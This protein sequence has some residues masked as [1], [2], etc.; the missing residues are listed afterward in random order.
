MSCFS[1]YRSFAAAAIL[2]AGLAS[3]PG[4]ESAGSQ[5]TIKEE[6]RNRWNL[7]RVGVLYQLAQQQ[8]QVG[9][10]DKCRETLKQA[11]ALGVPHA[12]I[13]IL[14]AKVDL[15][16]GNL[17]TAAAHL[18][19]ATQIDAAAPEPYYLLG[20]TYQRWQNMQTAHDYYK[21]AWE[22]KPTEP[23]YLLAVVEM[24]I[25]LGQYNEAQ[26]LLEEKIVY[27]EQSAAIRAALARI[28]TLRGDYEQACKHYR[29]ATILSPDDA[30]LRQNY[31]ESLYFAHRY[32]D[33]IPIFEDLRSNAALTDKRSL[34][35]LLGQSYLH[36]RR[37]RDARAV[38]SDQTH[39]DPNDMT[40]WINLGRA[41]L[42]LEDYVQAAGAARRVLKSEPQN[43]QALLLLGLAQQKLGQWD[44]AQATLARAHLLSPG[45]S[46]ILCL[47]GVSAQKLGQ[48]EQAQKFYSEA[49]QLNPQDTWAQEL[50]AA[51]R[52]TRVSP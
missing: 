24:K 16:K 44:Q 41:T 46:M 7:T 8:Y 1:H 4:C 20:V 3:L 25:T 14:A 47:L 49:L 33:A 43:V 35:T 32:A 29:D 28:C 23:L 39:D 40:A 17:E 45:D 34:L 50:L 22:K 37:P 48:L 15:E 27:F 10:Y 11:F 31:A 13:E 42:Q 30:N 26:K 9:D 52:P 12:P 21:L 36:A 6:Q 51:A 2:L 19:T 18:K 5:Q 38:F